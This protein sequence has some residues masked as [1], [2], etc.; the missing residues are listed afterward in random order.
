ML[1]SSA[2]LACTRAVQESSLSGQSVAWSGSFHG[3]MR[4]CGGGGRQLDT[5]DVV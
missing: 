5:E 3:P 2:L 1:D 4:I